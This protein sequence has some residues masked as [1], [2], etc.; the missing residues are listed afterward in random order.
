MHGE[1]EKSN[2]VEDLVEDIDLTVMARSTWQLAL[3]E[4]I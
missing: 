3:P 1:F 2:A 4:D